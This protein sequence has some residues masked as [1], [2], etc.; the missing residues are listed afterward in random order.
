MI[1][2]QVTFRLA[3][4]LSY[5]EVNRGSQRGKPEP[6]MTEEDVIALIMQGDDPPSDK[7]RVLREET[8]EHA[9]D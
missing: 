9:G 4:T 6:M 7:L 5:F 8:R 2:E 1:S 3:R